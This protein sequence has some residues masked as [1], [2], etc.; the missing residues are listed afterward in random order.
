LFAAQKLLQ[1]HQGDGNKS[2]R[3][4]GE[5]Y[6]FLLL[7]PGR[8]FTMQETEQPPIST[9][10]S[11]TSHWTTKAETSSGARMYGMKRD[12][13]IGSV[14]LWFCSQSN[15]KMFFSIRKWKTTRTPLGWAH[16]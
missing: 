15:L 5:N 16:V 11:S 6:Q 7:M 13:A 1:F 2:R 10:P 12:D 3:E 9:D 8:E 14:R 4:R